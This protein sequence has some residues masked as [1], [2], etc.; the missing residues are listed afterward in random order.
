[1]QV[2]ILQTDVFWEN[3]QANYDHLSKKIK[4]ISGVD[5]IVLP[6]MFTTGFSMNAPSIAEQH[7][8]NTLKWMIEIA[9]E[10]QATITGSIVVQENE[11]YYNRLY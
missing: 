10:K 1:M 9:K 11:K 6:E 4:N 2:A 3:P 7:N 5:L 8:G